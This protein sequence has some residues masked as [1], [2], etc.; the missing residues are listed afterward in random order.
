MLPVRSMVSP[1]EKSAC[2]HNPQKANPGRGICNIMREAQNRTAARNNEK[3][4]GQS[5][6]E[7]PLEESPG[8]KVFCLLG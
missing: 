4:R 8:S 2:Q 1:L 7:G 5:L 6:E 3:R